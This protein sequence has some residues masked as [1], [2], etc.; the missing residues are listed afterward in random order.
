MRTLF[1]FLA[2]ALLVPAI[3][4]TA[5]SKDKKE[6]EDHLKKLEYS[7]NNYSTEKYYD[8]YSFTNKKTGIKKKFKDFEELQKFLFFIMTGNVLDRELEDYGTKLKEDLASPD[9]ASGDATKKDLRN[10][11]EKLTDLRKSNA[12]KLEALIE[13]LFTKW[14]DEFTKEEQDY[15]SKSVREYHDKHNL[16]K[17][18]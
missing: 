7:V 16:I 15:I 3:A 5:F 12:V 1:K 8:G 9:V 11:L 6:Y 4:A 10:Y 17:R 18:D 14:P 2:V 13:E